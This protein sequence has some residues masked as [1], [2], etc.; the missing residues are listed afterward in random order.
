MALKSNIRTQKQISSS[1]STGRNEKMVAT[2]FLGIL[3]F[4]KQDVDESRF[5]LSGYRQS[6]SV[7]NSDAAAKK[8]AYS[9]WPQPQHLETNL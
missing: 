4:M 6:L 5:E 9:M 2:F 7:S 8:R 1:S 3:F